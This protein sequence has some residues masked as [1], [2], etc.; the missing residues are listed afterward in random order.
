MLTL[1]K[2]EKLQVLLSGAVTTTECPMT[3]TYE[4]GT[5]GRAARSTKDGI[6][7]S[8]TAVDLLVGSG[9]GKKITGFSINNADTVAVTVT[10]RFY[11][12][13]GTTRIVRVC[14]LQVN[15][16][17][18]WEEGNGWYATDANGN[19]KTTSAAADSANISIALSTATKGSSQ[20]SSI[21]AAIVP[22]SINSVSSQAS[23]IALAVIPA[24]VNSVSSQASSVAALNPNTV[25]SLQSGAS[26]QSFTS[27]TWST[28]SSAASRVKSSFTW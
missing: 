4:E 8:G 21:A 6:T 7:T 12:A 18:G 27:T 13:S 19:V 22:A 10:V 15:E 24:S 26:A 2:L 3:V 28:V 14:T 11:N 16:T 1:R 23:S 5:Q 9:T 25:S 17:L 20:A